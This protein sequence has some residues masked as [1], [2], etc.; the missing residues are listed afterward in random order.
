MTFEVARKAVDFFLDNPD[1]FNKDMVTW[2]FVGGEPLLEIG[3]IDAITDYIKVKTY[4]KDHK[5]FNQ[6]RIS[7]SSNGVLYNDD[8]VR[9]FVKKNA[10]K[11]GIGISIDG[12]ETKHNLQR[13]YPDGRGS[14]Q[15]VARNVPLWI[16]DFGDVN[17]KVT[18]GHDDLPYIKDSIVHLW[19]MGIKSVPANVVFEDVWQEGDDLIFEQQLRE[20]ADYVLENK[21]WDEV[22]CGLFDD[23]I[24]YPYDDEDLSSNYCGTG[25]M[26]AVDGDGNFYPC[27]RFM[28]LSLSNHEPIIIGNINDGI[29]FDK[30]RPFSGLDVITQSDD[31]CIDCEVASGCAWCQANNYDYSV[32]GSIYHRSKYICKMHKARCRANNYYFERLQKEH[33]IPK[34][35]RM[36]HKRH[37][38]FILADN[39]VE[40]C[41]YQSKT[42]SLNIMSDDTV[43]RAFRFAQN[44]YF[45]PVILHPKNGPINLDRHPIN[46]RIEIFNLTSKSPIQRGI[47]AIPV[48]TLG[49]KLQGELSNCV[50]NL[51]E[52]N[53]NGL[54]AYVEELLKSVARIN[55]NLRFMSKSFDLQSYEEQLRKMVDLLVDYC[56]VGSFKE[57]NVITDRLYLTRMDNCD[58]GNYNFALGPNGKI[59]ICPAFYFNDPDS[60][61]GSLEEGISVDRQQFQLHQSAFC[62]RCD[63]YHCNRCLFL[64]KQ[65]THEYNTPSSIQCKISFL[66]RQMSVLLQDKLA[67]EGLSIPQSKTVQSVAYDDA[68]AL[69]PV[70]Y[71]RNVYNTKQC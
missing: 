54:A 12:T 14:Y 43:E 57:I 67:Q 49:S 46:E 53:V 38:Y 61:I 50:L 44:N 63:A 2:E 26:I 27:L 4:E 21:L 17:T 56:R 36:P 69:L 25:K 16:S 18:I 32:T 47:K 42:T 37:L 71:T 29:D 52:E 70:Q 35:N 11:C 51:D 66:E 3:L 65:F 28:G 22:Y 1:L 48:L 58:F 39:S 55:I 68:M 19:N 5:W 20:L 60:F 34:E 6:Y 33:G 24:G 10:L 45:T 40:H 41:N 15:D 62:S 9:R 7:M 30:V 23:T 64:N 13:V 59:Y 31:E 8:R